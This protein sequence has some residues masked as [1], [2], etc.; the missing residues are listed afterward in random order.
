M[1]VRQALT[2]AAHVQRPEGRAVD[3]LET[4]QL[5]FRLDTQLD[6]RLEPDRLAHSSLFTPCHFLAKAATAECNRLLTVPSGMSS[7]SAI[8][9]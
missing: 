3:K 5:Q 2:P 8:W 1:V 7:A 6:T 9:L 4:D